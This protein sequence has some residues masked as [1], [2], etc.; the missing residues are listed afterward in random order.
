M[1]ICRK[2]GTTT[3]SVLHRKWHHHTIDFWV[4][5]SYMG[6]KIIKASF[7]RILPKHQSVTYKSLAQ[8]CHF[9]RGAGNMDWDTLS[10]GK[11]HPSPYWL[12][13]INSLTEKFRK[14]TQNV[15]LL[16]CDWSVPKQENCS[17]GNYISSSV[18]KQLSAYT[19]SNLLCFQHYFKF[20]FYPFFLRNAR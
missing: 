4:M 12:R 6:R 15:I 16:Q 8:C 1:L 10:P 9:L 17:P 3:M 11:F 20:N 19:Q 7:S 14:V 2:E 5:L 13:W 18:Y